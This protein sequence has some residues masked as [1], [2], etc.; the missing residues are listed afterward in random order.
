[1]TNPI[2][3]IVGIIALLLI[4]GG[5]TGFSFFGN[6]YS[7][8]PLPEQISKVPQ[9]NLTEVNNY[10]SYKEFADKTNDLISI[11]NEQGK[12]NIPKLQ[13]TQEA[14]GEVSKKIT[15]YGPL[16]NNYQN[17]TQSANIFENNK[18]KENY[19]NFY[20]SLGKFSLE[21]SVIGITL[22]YTASYQTVGILYRA[23]GLSNIALKCPSCVSVV[24]SSAYW[25]I[26]TVL[27]EETSKIADG[28]INKIKEYKQ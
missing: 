20:I 14:W 2:F 13:A 7:K 16:I 21:T 11:L 22:F 18:C 4:G 8:D 6:D 27:V 1:M 9:L 12:F 3:I 19:Q 28:I 23:S 17:L 26:K 10:E 24:L 25:T 15:K 5:I